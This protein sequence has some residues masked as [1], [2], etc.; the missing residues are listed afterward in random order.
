MKLDRE[1]VARYLGYRGR[2]LD[3]EIATLVEGCEADLLRVA[4][5]R[6]LGRRMEKAALPWESGDL[7]HH[8]RHCEEVYLTAITLGSEV[9]R[10]LRLWAAQNMAKAA[11]GQALAA[12]YMDECCD[13]YWEELRKDLPKGLYLLP[14]FSPGYWDFPLESQG[15]FLALLETSFRRGLSLHQG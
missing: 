5:P 2:P 9:D 13:A 10:L 3:E 4:K 7:S 1:E 12:V 15:S 11:V 8:L 14:G 6:R